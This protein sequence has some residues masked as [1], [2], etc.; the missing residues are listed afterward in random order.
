MSECLFCT[1][2]AGGTPARILDED[3]LVLAVDI[4]KD[5]PAKRAPV[6]FVVIPRTHLA[7]ARE[8]QGRDGAMLAAMIEMACKV[9]DGQ[10]TGESGFRLVTNSGPHANQTE[11]HMHLHCIGGRRL[12]AEG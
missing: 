7:S 5:H 3:D 11:F 12:G 10:G 9:A 4:P 2:A 1:V 6:H 8:L